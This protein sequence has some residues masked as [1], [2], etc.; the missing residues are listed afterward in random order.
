MQLSTTVLLI[1]DSTNPYSYTTNK[2]RNRTT[3]YSNEQGE[4]R[5]LLTSAFKATAYKGFLIKCH[6]KSTKRQARDVETAEFAQR[7]FK[8]ELGKVSMSSLQVYR[9]A[10]RHV[11]D[12]ASG[13]K[14]KSYFNKSCY[15]KALCDS[16]NDLFRQ[17]K[18][19]SG[20]TCKLD[21]CDKDGCNKR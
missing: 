11:S 4:T 9:S 12:I 14:V 21:C 6:L 2:L 5:I 7:L 15:T 17:C 3:I 20:A 16:G 8:N 13:V 18:K 1:L 10:S 19:I